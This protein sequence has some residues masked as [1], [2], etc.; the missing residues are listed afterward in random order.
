MNKYLKHFLSFFSCKILLII[1]FINNTI[2]N[3]INYITRELDNPNTDSFEKFYYN[4]LIFIY[5]T[6]IYIKQLIINLII[7]I[8]IE[9]KIKNIQIYELIFG[10]KQFKLSTPNLFY[11]VL[12]ELPP[13]STILD[14]GCGSGICYKNIDTINLIVKSNFKITGIDINELAIHKFKERINSNS[15]TDR[16]NLKYGD[17]LTTDF[18]EKFDYIILS[19]SAPLISKEFMIKIIFHIKNNLLKSGGK[20]IF[21]NNLIENPQFV[22]RFIKPKL[23]YVTTIDFGRVIKKDEFFNLASDNKMKVNFELLDSMTIEQIAKYHN[24]Y[25]IYKLFTIFGFKNYDVMQYKITLE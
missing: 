2:T 12:K 15:L 9:W 1:T 3:Y 11:S 4:I 24:I 19:E 5:W 10:N 6:I 8:N 25:F 14:F 7:L 20:I 21:I 13:N 16:I 18:I 17:I 23:K 22:T